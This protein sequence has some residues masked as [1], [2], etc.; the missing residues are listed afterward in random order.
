MKNEHLLV[1]LI[2]AFLV[3]SILLVAIWAQVGDIRKEMDTGN[4]TY[5]GEVQALRETNTALLEENEKLKNAYMDAAGDLIAVK[6][7]LEQMT[8]DEI[9][10]N[11]GGVDLWIQTCVQTL[12]G[13]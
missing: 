10:S 5:L 6:E 9:V 1:A 13:E 8:Y 7:I 3:E 2:A 4:Q 11:P 12:E